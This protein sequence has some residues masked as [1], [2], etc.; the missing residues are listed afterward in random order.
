MA[1]SPEELQRNLA[2]VVTE[3]IGCRWHL[4][5]GTPGT[6]WFGSLKKKKC[7]KERE[8][9][10]VEGYQLL[11]ALICASRLTGPV[12]R[13]FIKHTAQCLKESRH[14]MKD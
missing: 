3:G 8:W 9:A 7:T 14:S 12:Q 1:L 13:V 10:V 2:L 6:H 4:S 5:V 11:Q